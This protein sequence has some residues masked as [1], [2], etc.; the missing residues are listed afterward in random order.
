MRTRYLLILLVPLAVLLA[1]GALPGLIGGGDVYTVV[2]TETDL[3]DG[4]P[5][6]NATETI[7]AVNLSENRFPYTTEALTEGESDTYEEGR[8]GFEDSF[9]HT[10]FDEFSEFELWNGDATDG[11]VVWIEENGTYYRL[12]ITEVDD[13]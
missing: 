5:P 3:E 11:D 1:L 9:T 13:E 2:A 8:F 10:P 12:E 4:D 7:D 6:G